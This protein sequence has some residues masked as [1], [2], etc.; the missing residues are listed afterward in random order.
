MQEL[1]KDLPP[2]IHYGWSGIAYQEIATGGTSAA[3]LAAALIV[4][5]LILAA[6]YEKWSAPLVI[7]MAVPFAIFG[8]LLGHH[9]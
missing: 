4:V 9:H 6:L 3:V 8:A 1:A 2:D 5:F 7:I